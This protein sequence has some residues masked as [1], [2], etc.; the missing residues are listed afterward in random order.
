M[1]PTELYSA[2]ATPQGKTLCQSPSTQTG[3][4]EVWNWTSRSHH[5]PWL[6]RADKCVCRNEVGTKARRG[7]IATQWHVDAVALNRNFSLRF[8]SVNQFKLIQPGELIS[9]DFPICMFVRVDS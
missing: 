8:C 1:S 3:S 6:D 2:L 5:W 9:I 4:G 7:V